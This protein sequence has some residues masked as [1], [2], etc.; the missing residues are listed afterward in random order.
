MLLLLLAGLSGESSPAVTEYAVISPLS[1]S[2]PRMT[3]SVATTRMTAHV[4]PPRSTI[5]IARE[6]DG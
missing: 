6:S 1:L 4:S 3:A 5:S 2:V